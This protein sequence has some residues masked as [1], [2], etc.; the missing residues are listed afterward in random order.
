M[1][2]VVVCTYGCI[3]GPLQKSTKM[4]R[5]VKASIVAGQLAVIPNY[6]NMV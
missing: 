3:S 5:E 1:V 4:V 2:L 6:N